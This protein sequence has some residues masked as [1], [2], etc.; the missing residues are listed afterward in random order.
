VKRRVLFLLLALG[1]CRPDLGP[2]DSLVTSPRVL[3]I[4]ADPPEAKPGTM[5]TYTALVADAD[6]SSLVWHFCI[7]PKPLTDTGSVASECVAGASLVA[8]GSGSSIRAATAPNA[9]A[10]FGP[11]TPPGGFRPR[12]PDI[13]GGYYQPLLVDGIDGP[14]LYLARIRCNLGGASID[15]ATQYGTSYIV[16]A[17][18]K[19]ASL[20]ARVANADVS[21]DAI[22]AG[23]RVQL[24]ASWTDADAES[25]A[26]FNPASQ[27][28]VTKRESIR[29]AWFAS[30]GT[31]DTE[32]TG[33][34]EDDPATTSQNMWNA[35]AAGAAMLWVVLRDSR[36]GVD[37][38]AFDV[39]VVR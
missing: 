7:A 19:L 16:N 36:G 8:A 10:L 17:N 25:Y 34:A 3:A 29:V 39:T 38:A 15:V 11:D 2:S 30:A 4:Q 35:P 6:G 18:P 9:C 21:L 32:S 14:T 33:R 12:D 27:T 13:T 1:A 5:A 22:P 37:F 31:L 26:Y 28:I 24:E 20:V 23:A